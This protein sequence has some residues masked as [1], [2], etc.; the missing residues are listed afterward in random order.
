MEEMQRVLSHRERLVIPAVMAFMLL[1]GPS[2][3]P[4]AAAEQEDVASTILSLD[5]R[6]WQAYNSCDTG[7]FRQFFTEDVEFYHDKGGATLGVE[8]LLTTMKTNLCGDGGRLRREAVEGTVKVFPL[9]DQKAVYGAI[10]SGEHLFYVQERGKA[11]RLDGRARFTH[12]WLRSGA[13]WRMARI[14]SYDHGPATY[15]NKRKAVTL[16]ESS[17]DAFVGPYRAPQ[18]GSMSVRRED[19]TLVL[20][21]GGKSDGSLILHP[22]GGGLFFVMERDLTFEF[23]RGAGAWMIQVRERGALVEEAVADR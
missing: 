8:S 6:F 16:P 15:V 14:L 1:A 2:F 11:E 7:A 9:H 4:K 22:E 21:F 17:L 19:G 18:S 5:D 23:V 10:L 20:S 12:L 3:P 13:T